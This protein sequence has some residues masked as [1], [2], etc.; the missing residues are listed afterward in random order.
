[1]Q[2]VNNCVFLALLIE[3]LPRGGR[4][5]VEIQSLHHMFKGMM[6]YLQRTEATFTL[7]FES[8]NIILGFF[9]PMAIFRFE[10]NEHFVLLC[11]IFSPVLIK[12]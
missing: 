1:M 2:Y 4:C 10:L 3:E 6:S 11:L 12:L 9:L 8:P 5:Y 7:F